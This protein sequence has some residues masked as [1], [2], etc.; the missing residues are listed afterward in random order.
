MMPKGRSYATRSAAPMKV[1]FTI[2]PV[3]HSPTH[4]PQG[5]PLLRRVPLAPPRQ[6]HQ[7]RARSWIERGGS[8]PLQVHLLLQDLA[9]LPR[10]REQTGSEPLDGGVDGLNV[11]S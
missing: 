7:A 8:Q 6:S 2:P 11:R 5:L 4:G 1:S 3:N 9:S 10:R